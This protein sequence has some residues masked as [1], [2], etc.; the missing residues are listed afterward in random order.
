MLS[1]HGGISTRV[2]CFSL[3][4]V[5]VF[6][7]AMAPGTVLAKERPVLVS[8]FLDETPVETIVPGALRYGGLREDVPVVEAMGPE[9]LLGYVLLTSDF[10]TT[11]GYS[12][13]PIHVLMG[14]DLDAVITGVRLVKHS[15]P[16]VLVGIPEAKITAVTEGYVGLNL[17]KE[18]E[19]ENSGHDL[20]IVSG[21]TVTIMVI[22]DS[23]LRAGLRA[24]RALGLGGLQ[25]E[26]AKAGPLRRLRPEPEPVPASSWQT[27][28]GDGSVRALQL[29][30]RQVNQAFELGGDERA[31]K[32]PESGSPDETFIEM[33][34]ALLSDREIGETLLGDEEYANLQDWLKE[35]EH[36]I[37][38]LGRGKYSFKGS[39]YISVCPIRR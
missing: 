17:R 21:A 9:G 18:S 13:K 37:L 5:L 7:V 38:V 11:T 19:A 23:I 20:D 6:G 28:S 16:I 33:Q 8:G 22:D 26:E 34:L 4:A 35:G 27:L 24:A 36:A 30:L 31:I 39:G 2:R 3:L 12:G 29:D 25:P 15:E 14:I 10:V 1:D 32:R